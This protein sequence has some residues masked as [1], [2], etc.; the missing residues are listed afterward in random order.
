VPNFGDDREHDVLGGDAR[1]R[2]AVNCH[3]QC[4]RLL[5]PQ[6]LRR[7]NLLQLRRADT[8]RVSAER[9]VRRG[10]R[11]AARDDEPGLRDAELRA[12]HV[13]DALLRML[14]TEIIFNAVGFGILFEQIEH[15]EH[16]GI[17]DRGETL[18]AVARRH[19]VVGSCERL[20][21][22][23]HFAAVEGE[24]LESVERAFVHEIA[25]DVQQR[26]ILAALHDHVAVPD[27]F[28]QGLR[29]GAASLAV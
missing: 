1:G 10:V 24:R 19:V 20:A 3:A 29:H 4:L 17:G 15:V 22:L 27:F 9:A 16:F 28:E 7:E 2:R 26:F 18:L 13:D 14:E 5:L 25:V 12:D 6:A 11:V 23:A 8:D 21:R